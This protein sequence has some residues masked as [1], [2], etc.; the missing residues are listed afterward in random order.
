MKTEK[1]RNL[2]GTVLFTV[3]SVLSIMIIFMTCTLAMASA[4]HKRARKTY[5]TAQSSYTARSAIDSILAAIGTDKDFSKAVRSL[6]E[7][8]EMSIVVNVNNPSMGRVENATIKYSGTKTVFDPS[9]DVMSWITCNVYT[10]TADVTIGSETT[11]ITASVLQDPPQGGGGGGGA[12]FLTWGGADIDNHTYAWG[13]TYVGMGKWGDKTWNTDLNYIKWYNTLNKLTV[14]E[15]KEYL[16]NM[17]YHL[18]NDMAF[19]SPVVINGNLDAVNG[20]S[21]YYTYN[22]SGID[23][24]GVQIWGDLDTGGND[25]LRFYMTDSLKEYISANG[26]SFNTMSYLYVDGAIRSTKMNLGSANM[27]L[28]VFCGKIDSKQN[29]CNIYADVYCMDADEV[30]TISSSNPTL[31]KWANSVVSGGASYSTMGGNFYS[32]GS[33][34][35]GSNMTINGNMIV[36]GNLNVKNGANLKVNGYLVVGGTLIK[37]GNVTATTIY[38]D[39]AGTYDEAKKNEL[40]DHIQKSTSNALIDYMAQQDAAG[41]VIVKNAAVSQ[42]NWTQG[43]NNPQYKWAKK[44]FLNDAKLNGRYTAIADP[45]LGTIYDFGG[46]GLNYY[47]GITDMAAD[48]YFLDNIYDLNGLINKKNEATGLQDYWIVKGSNPEVRVTEKEMAD[49]CI[50]P[51]AGGGYSSIAVYKAMAGSGGV[52]YPARAERETL[53]GLSWPV[54]GIEHRVKAGSSL[55][56]ADYAATHDPN[57]QYTGTTLGGM[58]ITQSCTLTGEFNNTVNVDVG[59]QDIYIRLYNVNFK[60]PET[61]NAEG[62]TVPNNAARI[63]I[64][65]NGAGKCYFILE[66]SVQS[67]Y[68]YS[69][70]NINTKLVKTVY[71]WQKEFNLEGINKTPSGRDGT[72]YSG[73]TGTTNK[74]KIDGNDYTCIDSDATLTGMWWASTPN[75]TEDIV[76]KAPESGEIWITLDNFRTDNKRRIIVED[77]ELDSD[78]NHV[79]DA[80][81]RY[82]KVGGQVYFYV[83]GN[84]SLGSGGGIVARSI[85]HVI[86]SGDK[87]NI[88]SRANDPVIT[89]AV[90][91]NGYPV[92]EPL[93]VRVYSAKDASLNIQDNSFIT[94]YISAIYMSI[95]MPTVN[96]VSFANNFYYD[97]QLLSATNPSSKRIGV[98]GMLNVAA[99]DAQ[100]D[101]TLLYVTEDDSQQNVIV[102]AEGAHAYEA[103]NYWAY[104][105]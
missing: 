104:A 70:D 67:N 40:F 99:C 41:K 98:I 7:N 1:N 32:K 86:D 50:V 84:C 83:K 19:E 6:D 23:T 96:D 38:C 64:K 47:T 39:K 15:D 34:E 75:C 20:A 29:D 4:A 85:Q 105:N 61:V 63:V 78:G 18:Q 82:K 33:V 36:E 30:S 55:E 59:D 74:A 22:S 8:G 26:Y 97:G 12:A 49:A 68:D 35:I 87:V 91:A 65:E 58:H 25:K 11:T 73:T 69:G 88:I 51:G 80:N 9:E 27:P 45:D 5:S 43:A 76:I 28:N 48:N 42:G 13:G 31:Y 102:D 60:S 79:K 101:W 52:I 95:T 3:V 81:G 72:L 62:K 14:L 71:D 16:T 90:A 46:N 37:A 17:N 24:P 2:K 56:D 54:K 53:L 94:A 10:I 89:A 21:I 44:T 100:N 57:K 93:S 77:C 103:V 92:M 66:G